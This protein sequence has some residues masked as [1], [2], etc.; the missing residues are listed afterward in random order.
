MRNRPN[1]TIGGEVNVDR[2]LFDGDHGYRSAS[3]PTARSTAAGE[4][5]LSG[6]TYGSAA[7]LLRSGVGPAAD[8]RAL[9]I[10][11]VADLPVGQR[12]QDQPFFYNAYALAPE[13]LEMTPA[14]GSLLWTASSEAMGGEL[15][16]HITATPPARR[17]DQPDRRRDRAGHLGRA[18]RVARDPRSW[19]V[20]IRTTA[21]VIDNN[22]L[23]TERDRASHGGG[24]EA[25][26][27]DRPQ[28][29]L[30]S[31]HR[32]RD[33]ARRRRR[34]MTRCPR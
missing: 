30:R 31:V 25:G 15:D 17:L 8:L 23:G 3:Q 11:V 20:A 14:V 29:G 1:L 33:A 18:A 4:V 12:L 2:V 34:T 13:Y 32:R 24:R 28:P 7:I 21:P 6:G 19:P 16:L 5:I 27:G 9:G 26:A 22:Y 10:D